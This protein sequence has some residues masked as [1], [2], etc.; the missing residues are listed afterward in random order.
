MAALLSLTRLAV[1]G[2]DNADNDRYAAVH[3]PQVMARELHRF[4]IT[5][6]LRLAHHSQ[7][8]EAGHPAAE[9][10]LDQRVDACPVDLAALG[11]RG[12]RDGVDAFCTRIEQRGHFCCFSMVGVI[13]S[14]RLGKSNA[15]FSLARLL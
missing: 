9:V 15:L 5:E 4:L 7:D 8:G 6:F 14:V 3:T 1:P 11:E 12:R 2:F 10:E 13:Y